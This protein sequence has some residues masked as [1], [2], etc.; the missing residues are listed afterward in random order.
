MTG[1]H[2]TSRPFPGHVPPPPPDRDVTARQ[3]LD[4]AR[5]RIA[6]RGECPPTCPRCSGG[7]AKATGRWEYFGHA[8]G[9][10]AGCGEP[11][12]SFDSKGVLRHPQSECGAS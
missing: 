4:A 6:G 2:V 11:C 8:I 9:D 7:Q 5:R 12:R 10:C 3:T 1:L